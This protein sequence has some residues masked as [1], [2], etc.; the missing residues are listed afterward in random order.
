MAKTK[1]T[2]QSGFT[3]VELIIAMTIA[4]IPIFV[5]GIIL[6]DSQRGWN[7]MYNRVYSDVVTDSYVARKTFD[8]IIRK[9]D[10]E[11]ITLADDGSWIEV[12]YYANSDS[13]VIDRYARFYQADGDLNIEHGVLDTGEILSTQ[14]VCSNVSNCVFKGGTGR[15]AQMILTLDNGTQALTTVSSAIMHN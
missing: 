9:G 5:V 14:T 6:S 8:T 11:K 10:R 2:S 4:I 12:H 15:S 7:N 3:L 1:F 13:T